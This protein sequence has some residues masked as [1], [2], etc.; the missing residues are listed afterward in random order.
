MIVAMMVVAQMVVAQI[1]ASSSI[2]LRSMKPGQ[3]P[4]ENLCIA[5]YLIQNYLQI[6]PSCLCKVITPGNVVLSRFE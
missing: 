3:W 4:F 5:F 6:I 2:S 1:T